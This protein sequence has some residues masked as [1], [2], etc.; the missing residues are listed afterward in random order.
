MSRVTRWGNSNVVRLSSRYVLETVKRYFNCP[1][2][3]G[4]Y[5]ENQGAE[6]SKGSHWET[7]LISNEIMTPSLVEA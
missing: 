6:G 4:M 2:I 5:L 3:E 1:T 7:D